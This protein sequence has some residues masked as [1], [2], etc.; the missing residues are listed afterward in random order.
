MIA[1]MFNIVGFHV[2]E[3]IGDIC[4]LPI[5]AEMFNIVGFHVP[6]IIGNICEL[7]QDCREKKREKK[8]L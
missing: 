2:P 5:V 1:E 3:I 7:S 6:K 8:R 4:E